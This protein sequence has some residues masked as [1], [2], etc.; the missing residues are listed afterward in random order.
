MTKAK[1][2]TSMIE[3]LLRRAGLACLA[4]SLCLLPAPAEAQQRSIPVV[5]DT[6]IEALV[7]D[8]TRPILEAAGLTRSGV[9]IILVNNNSFNAFVAGRRMFIHTGALAAAE[10]PNEI[11]GVIAHE[12]GHLAGGHQERLREQLSRAETMAVV[13]ALLGMGA[14]VAGAATG[15]GGLAQAGAGIAIGGGEMA[16]RGFL[17]YQRSEETTADRSAITYLERTGQSGRGMLRTFERFSGALALS[18]ARV[19]P[20]QQSHPAP[21]ERIVALQDLVRAS[22]YYER[23][24]PPELQLRHDMARAKIAA[25]TMGH[26][27][28]QRMFR[29]NIRS[30]PAA[31][32]DAIQTYLY[33]NPAQAISKIDA[34][35][36]QQ[37]GNPYFH[38]LRG[39]ALI[40]ANRPTEAIDSLSRAVQNVRGNS[41]LMRVGLGQALVA[42][43]TPDALARAV[44]ELR[45]G[46]DA[47]PEFASGW[48]S[49]AQ[50]YGM[51]GEVAQAEL[52]TA[53]SHF[54][55]GAIRDAKIFAAR[56]QQRLANGSPGW[57]RAQDII[58]FRE[59]GR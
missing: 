39:Q 57:V 1:T 41:G 15:S 47:A 35:I 19:D 44:R 43:G 31:Y 59:P 42:I 12:A 4:A 36:A 52:A 45:A 16:R 21:R 5:R 49:L 7:R 2:G 54:H 14:G 51:Q 23:T 55:R 48:E 11:I 27:A 10:T 18:G 32:G 26:G 29:D 37:P 9:E 34:L 50:A 20:Y 53:E 24:D 25:Y 13:A 40:R 28:V 22:R 38:E 8:Y 30:L 58:N 33:G 6:E 56:A 46:L 17:S 3:G